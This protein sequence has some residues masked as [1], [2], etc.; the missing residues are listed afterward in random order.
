[1]PFPFGCP[2][3]HLCFKLTK[4][5]ELRSI[6]DPLTYLIGAVRSLSHTDGRFGT[7]K[8]KT[9]VVNELQLTEFLQQQVIKN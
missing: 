6:Q 2:G 8:I 7:N 5:F 3:C 9:T 1:M 4:S